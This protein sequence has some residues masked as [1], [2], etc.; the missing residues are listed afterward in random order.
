MSTVLHEEFTPQNEWSAARNISPR[1][2]ARYRQL[3][4]SFM[5][6]GGRIYI[7][8]REGDEWILLADTPA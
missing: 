4:L 1:T 8:N 3:G 5:V 2:T 7:H 6:F